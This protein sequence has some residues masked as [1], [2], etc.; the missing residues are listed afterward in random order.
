MTHPHIP[1]E[2]LHVDQPCPAD[3]NAMVGDDRKRF[4][5][6]CGKHVHDLSA[7]PRPEA[8]RLV[9]ESAG[10]LCIRM[11]LAADGSVATVDY[12]GS[13][14]TRPR[15]GWRFWT[16]VGLAGALLTGVV[17]AVTGKTPVPPI[18]ITTPPA[19]APAVRYVMGEICPPVITTT[20]SSGPASPVPQTLAIPPRP[21]PAKQDNS[22][23]EPLFPP[24]SEQQSPFHV[25]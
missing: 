21:A 2:V 7:M 12:Q 22:T 11:E 24:Q 17:Q 25:D 10:H 20:S 3:W 1:L 4:C 18:T 23:D 14:R 15:R 5:Q 19:T 6:G 16:G 8:E 13:T 9:C